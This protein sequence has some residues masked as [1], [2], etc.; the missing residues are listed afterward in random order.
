M[1]ADIHYGKHE[2]SF[3]RTHPTRVLFAGKAT[4]EVLGDNFLP[5][6]T[7]GD[8]RQ[9]VATDTMKNLVYALALE[10]PGER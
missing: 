5:A 7:E 9:V 8:N 10:F 6:Y 2:V 3:Y 4:V 1:K